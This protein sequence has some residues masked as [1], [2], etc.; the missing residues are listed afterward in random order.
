MN[1]KT[2]TFTFLAVSIFAFSTLRSQEVDVYWMADEKIINPHNPYKLDIKIVQM[3]PLLKK[4][5]KLGEGQRIYLPTECFSLKECQTI[6]YIFEQAKIYTTFSQ[7]PIVF[8]SHR[9]LKTISNLL[10]KNFLRLF[11]KDNSLFEHKIQK[12]IECIL[13]VRNT[14]KNLSFKNFTIILEEAHK[15]LVAALEVEQKHSHLLEQLSSVWREPQ[16]EPIVNP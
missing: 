4:L 15:T 14:S 8:Y 1:N 11:S 9:N 16:E 7:F 10:A 3:S 12:A 13:K 5:L 6:F 2:K